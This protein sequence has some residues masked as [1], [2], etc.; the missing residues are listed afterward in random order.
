MLKVIVGTAPARTIAP[1]VGGKQ[2]R[3]FRTQEVGIVTLDQAGN[4]HQFP[5]RVEITLEDNEQP[6]AAGV[7]TFDANSAVF[8]DQRGR[9]A[10][11][12][13]KLTPAATK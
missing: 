13:V 4:P 8:V 3:A 1:K 7:Y 12:R 6:Y 11:G 9:L 5:Q 10:L 2:F